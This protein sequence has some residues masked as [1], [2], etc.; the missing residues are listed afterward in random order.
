[1]DFF[2]DRHRFHSRF[3]PFNVIWNISFQSDLVEAVAVAVVVVFQ[4]LPFCRKRNSIHIADGTT[5]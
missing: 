4:S 1:M 3:S 5:L 2:P